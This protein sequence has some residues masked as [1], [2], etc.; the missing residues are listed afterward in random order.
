MDLEKTYNRV[1][2]EALWQILRMYDV[3]GKLINGVRSMYVDS[4]V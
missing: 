2:R 4:L 1:T 3:G